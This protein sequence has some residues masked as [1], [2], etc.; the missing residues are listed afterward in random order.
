MNVGRYTTHPGHGPVAGDGTVF[1]ASGGT[2]R[3]TL[4]RN[5]IQR[6][7]AN[8]AANSAAAVATFKRS[9][10]CDR[11]LKLQLR[12]PL[13]GTRRP[14]QLVVGPKLHDAACLHDGDLA[15]LADRAQP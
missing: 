3:G 9:P 6:A 8:A 4:A 12:Q 2:A 10:S 13:V 15:R 11:P 1:T 5:V 14:H 7:T